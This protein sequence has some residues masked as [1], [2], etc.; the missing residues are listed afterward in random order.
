MDPPSAG[1]AHHE[2]PGV[3]SA[4]VPPAGT[5]G[6]TV[7]ARTPPEGRPRLSAEASDV[8]NIRIA[9]PH[10]RGPAPRSNTRRRRSR[11]RDWLATIPV[12]L[13][14]PAL[15][16]P[17]V[18]ADAGG[19]TLSVSPDPAVPGGTVRVVGTRFQAGDRGVLAFD[20]LATPV[21]YTA[22]P[23]GQFRARLSIGGGTPAGTHVIAARHGD[24]DVAEATVQVGSGIQPTADASSPTPSATPAASGS[25]PSPTPA[26]SD[27]TAGSPAPTAMASAMPDPTATA[28]PSSTPTP[29]ETPA[30]ATTPAPTATPAPV[31]AVTSVLV[32]RS[33]VSSLP[34]SGAAWTALKARADA[35]L[36]T[37]DIANQDDGTD[38]G[39]LARALVYARTGSSSYRSSALAGIRAAVGTEAGGRTLALGR[40]LPGYVI[41]ADLISLRTLDPAFDQDVFRP[42]LRSLLT[43]TLDGRTLRSTH[44]DRPNNWGTH[45][46]A[47]R[48]AIAAYLGDAT[49]MARVAKVF[50]G[51]TGDRA[52]YAGFSFGTDLSWQCDPDHPVAVNPTGCSRDGIALDGALPDE[53]RR[54]GSL[55]WPPTPTDYAWEGLQGA[56]LQAEILSQHGYDAWGWSNGALLRAVRFLYERA[57][58][59]ATGDDEWQ[60]WLIDARYGTSLRGPAPARTGK[61][62]GFTDWLYAP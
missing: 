17:F 29:T 52:A 50:R 35:T 32:S 27:G 59:P 5:P 46:G 44:E 3:V 40:N 7:A 28:A 2:P 8:R 24:V 47:A 9:D 61:N 25:T 19:P 20:G 37:P 62:F 43:E 54:G 53:M 1:L 58:W 31:A 4:T 22:N 10:D 42:W 26:A 48:A 45:A 41:A 21:T 49:E 39:V 33:D 55:T 51:W 6:R 57:G 34:T 14:L 60:P 13:L 30:L 56:L 18:G 36:G 16:L 38:I 23:Q 12:L 11:T 15:A